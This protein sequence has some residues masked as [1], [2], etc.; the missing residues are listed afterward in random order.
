MQQSTQE[1]A[2]TITAA[3]HHNWV[4]KLNLNQSQDVTGMVSTSPNHGVFYLTHQGDI[5]KFDLADLD[6]V[7]I[8]E[9]KWWQD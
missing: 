8:L 9:E 3:Y 2:S 7:T 5:E 6:D 1:L 4:I